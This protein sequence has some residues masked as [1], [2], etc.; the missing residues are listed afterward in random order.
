MRHQ[1]S[2]QTHQSH[3]LVGGGVRRHQHSCHTPVTLMG[4][5]GGGVGGGGIS[6]AVTH[7]TLT[8]GGWGGVGREGQQHSSETHQLHS[9]REENNTAVHAPTLPKPSLPS[10]P[11]QC[12]LVNL[13]TT[14][15]GL[16][17]QE[18][19]LAGNRLLMFRYQLQFTLHT[20]KGGTNSHCK[21]CTLAIFLTN[22]IQ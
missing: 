13:N 22:C 7:V 2:C 14:C 18:L 5:G 11:A 15:K 20:P 6:T 16:G 19:V 1:H 10:C 3:S 21:S 8:W 12:V 9:H 4:G 17:C